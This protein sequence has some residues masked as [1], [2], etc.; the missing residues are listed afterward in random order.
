MWPHRLLR[1]GFQRTTTTFGYFVPGDIEG[2]SELPYT[3]TNP[4]QKLGLREAGVNPSSE[5]RA[6]RY[7]GDE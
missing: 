4:V 2:V 6:A 7:T 5:A 3:P 1:S